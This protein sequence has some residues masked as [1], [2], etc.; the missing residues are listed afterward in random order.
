[1]TG[2]FDPPLIPGLRT[3]EGIV[4]PVEEAALIAAIDA[5]GLTPFQFGAHQGKRLT[6]SFGL[7]YDFT[8]HQLVE[9]EP[10][11]SWL[12]PLRE[13]AAAFAGLDPDALVHAL[14]IRYDPEAG[15]GWHKDRPVFDQVI[16]I[17][18]GGT[19]DMAFRRR[20]LDQ[21]FDRF[22]LPLGPRTAYLLSGEARDGWEHGIAAHAECRHS[23]T[24]RSLRQRERRDAPAVGK[25][26]SGP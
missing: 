22:R 26:S 12:L 3:T 11:P 19:T 17:S 13:L 9:T 25:P 15:I 21:R 4:D 6:R 10:L 2:L 1:M 5:S 24:F 8:H 18:L 23:V 16:G 14:L 7:Q 20:R